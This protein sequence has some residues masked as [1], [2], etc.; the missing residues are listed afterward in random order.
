MALNNV[1]FPTFGRPTIPAVNPIC[2]HSSVNP[3][4]LIIDMQ[5]LCEK[6]VSFY[7]SDFTSTFFNFF[8]NSFRGR[9]T[10]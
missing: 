7:S 3:F 5:M 2:F 6:S 8:S 1:D 4:S 9:R 10:L